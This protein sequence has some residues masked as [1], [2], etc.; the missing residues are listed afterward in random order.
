[1]KHTIKSVRTLAATLVT[2]GSLAGGANGA[3]VITWQQSGPNVIA[4]SSGSLAEP[5]GYI[6]NNVAFG[7][8]SYVYGGGGY[9]GQQ[10]VLTDS[11]NGV[12]IGAFS[13]SF[14]LSNASQDFG[15][16]V[17]LGV[18]VGGVIVDSNYVYG[19]NL[20]SGSTWA[21][22]TL[23]NLNLSES[24]FRVITYDTLAGGTDTITLQVIP[25]PS[26]AV[27]FGFAVVGFVL[28]RSKNK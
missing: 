4:N 1:M 25:E 16:Y 10:A 26:T 15:Y 20:V 6:T 3:L 12:D 7:I 5:M 8:P 23:A 28:R 14:T 22:T 2:L 21:S 11:W 18:A 19:T 17:G 9:I 13:A 27:L 24:D